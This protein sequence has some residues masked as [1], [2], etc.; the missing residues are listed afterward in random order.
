MDDVMVRAHVEQLDGLLAQ[1][2]QLPDGEARTRALGAIDGL[3]QL[4]G[5]ALRRI[6]TQFAAAPAALQE[7]RED[8]LVSH[9]MLLHDVHPATLQER[10]ARALEEVRPYMGS[11]GGGIELLDVA[12]G[13]ARV[14][15]EGT[16]SSCAASTLTLKLAVEEAVL[17]AA[18]ELRAVEAIEEKEQLAAPSPTGVLLPILESGFSPGRS[19]GRWVSAGEAAQL[20]GDGPLRLE[21]AGSPLLFARAD[22]ELYAY[23]D[24]CPGCHVALREPRLEEGALCCGGCGRRFDVR[25]AGV[26][27]DGGLF[28]LDPVPLLVEEGQVRVAVEAAAV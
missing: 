16:C 5:E 15:L 14:R 19:A 3:L 7:L 27:V 18:P 11:H 24:R 1:V 23:L 17:R 2:E 13:V 20:A 26:G 28:G 21:V 12:D 22:G 25:R 8:E 4:Y 9:L 6:V 10:V